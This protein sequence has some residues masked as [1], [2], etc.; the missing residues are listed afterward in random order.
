MTRCPTCRCLCRTIGGLDADT[1]IKG[2]AF[3]HNGEWLQIEYKMC[4]QASDG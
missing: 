2:L 4:E 1:T 3:H